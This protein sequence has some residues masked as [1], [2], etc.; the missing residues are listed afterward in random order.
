[1]VNLNKPP[2]ALKVV[3]PAAATEVKDK[4]G[5]TSLLAFL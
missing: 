4:E 2:D 1:L 5:A 3:I